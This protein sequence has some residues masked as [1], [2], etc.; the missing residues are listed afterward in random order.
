MMA[1]AINKPI[2]TPATTPAFMPGEGV[3]VAVGLGVDGDVVV[4]GTV[5]DVGVDVHVLVP[6]AAADVDVGINVSVPGPEEVDVFT[7]AT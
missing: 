2:A 6:E 4:D 7:I 3:S 1:P 5:V